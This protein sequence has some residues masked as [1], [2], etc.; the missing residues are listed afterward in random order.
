V[1]GEPSAPTIPPVEELL[2]DDEELEDEEDEELDDD[3]LD[4]DASDEELE[5]S[6][7]ELEASDEELEASDEVVDEL[8][9]VPEASPLLLDPFMLPTDAL[10]DALAPPAPPM[11]S[12][13][14]GWE[15]PVPSQPRAARHTADETSP[16]DRSNMSPPSAGGHRPWKIQTRRLT[17]CVG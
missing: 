9:V 14:I 17:R 4:D 11:E 16:R 13:S 1:H 8:V 12:S 7:E 6:D 5:A 10:D 3:E 2:L 15:H